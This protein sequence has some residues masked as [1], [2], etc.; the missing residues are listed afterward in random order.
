M[1]EKIS[2]EEVMSKILS[3]NRIIKNA[4]SELD[5]LEIFWQNKP[6]MLWNG[7]KKVL[8]KLKKNPKAKNEILRKFRHDEIKRRMS[9]KSSM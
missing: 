5:G 3:T 8:R 2:K 1:S 7:D 4:V 9:V 6:G